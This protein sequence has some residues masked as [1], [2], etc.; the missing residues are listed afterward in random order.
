MTRRVTGVQTCALPIFA[1]VPFPNHEL[2]I[3][4]EHLPQRPDWLRVLVDVQ[5]DEQDQLLLDD[6]VDRQQILI[7]AGDN[8]QFVIKE[9]HALVQ[10]ALDFRHAFAVLERLRQVP[11]GHFEVQPALGADFPVRLNPF[12]GLLDLL[13]QHFFVERHHDH[14]IEVE[15]QPC[16]VQYTNDVGQVVQLVFREELIVQIETAEHHVHLGHVVLVRRVKRVVQARQ[17]GPRGIDEPQVFESAG[18][19]DMRSPF[20]SKMT[21]GVL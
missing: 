5:R 15:G 8:R 4:Q 21:I 9:S 16:V 14:V 10:Q 13:L 3:L 7:R 6:V 1:L 11:D 17:F 12:P 18:R 20:P 19:S 2:E